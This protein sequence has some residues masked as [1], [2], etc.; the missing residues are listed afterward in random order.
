MSGGMCGSCGEG[1]GMCGCMH[2]KALPILMILFALTFLGEAMGLWS[3][4]AVSYTW[5]ILLLLAD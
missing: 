5:P 1:K 2:H 4:M 3:A